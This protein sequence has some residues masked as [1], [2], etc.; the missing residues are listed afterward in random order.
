MGIKVMYRK[1]LM[2]KLNGYFKSVC[3][4]LFFGAVLCCGPKQDE[5]DTKLFS[6]EKVF[7]IDTE[8]NAV[9]ETGLTDISYFDIDSEGKIF[10]ANMKVKENYLFI[11][12]KDGSL[13]YVFGRNGQGPGELQSPKELVISSQGEI[14]VTDRGKVV[15]FSNTGQFIKEFR[16][17]NDY[18]KFIPLNKDRNL[19]IVVK[20]NEDLSQSFEVVLCSSEL[21][22]LI[23]LDR[24]KIE[25][26][27]KAVKVNIIPTL[28]YW[29]KSNK[30]IYTGNTAEYEIRVFDFNGILLRQIKKDYKAVYLSDEDKEEYEQRLQ[31]YPPEIKDSFFIPDSFPP[32]RAITA[33]DDKW[34]FIQTYEKSTAGNFIYDVFDAKGEYVGRTELE[35]YQVKFRGDCVYCLRQ[36]DSGY[37]ELVVYRVIWN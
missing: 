16:I 21:E 5:K 7:T 32:V 29:E 12:N 6:L 8:D 30:Y 18:Q 24:S 34:L 19:A 37:K 20:L 10:I 27:N 22:E 31:K 26:F 11:L 3:F 1:A 4:I 13:N 23:T 33:V 17:N 15:V 9:A 14:F 28:V 35:G 25:S 2:I 36:K